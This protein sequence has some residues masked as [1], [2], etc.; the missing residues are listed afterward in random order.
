MPE[1]PQDQGDLRHLIATIEALAGQDAK[2]SAACRGLLAKLKAQLTSPP[3]PGS[4][5]AA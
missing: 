4:R 1:R 3:P 5:S 2:K